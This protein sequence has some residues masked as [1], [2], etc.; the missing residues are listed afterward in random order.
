MSP[1]SFA[2]GDFLSKVEEKVVK[3]TIDGLQK[4]EIDFVGFVF[5]GLMNCN[6]EP[7]VIEYN[8]RMGDPETQVVLPRIESDFL[9]HLVAAAK[10]DLGSETIAFKEETATT[11]VAVAGGYPGSYAKGKVISGLNN[12]SS[13]ITF[14]AGTQMIADTVV[15][16]GGRVI[17]STGL[18]DNI[19]SALDQSYKN[20]N[21]ICWDNINFRKDIGQ[22]LLKLQ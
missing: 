9:G 13:A 16:N 14:H 19:Q 11:V 2:K 6:G 22:D 3:R 12:G 7:Y 21:Q 18:G 17:A 4:D 8:V 5:I 20:L 15:T 10:R 1:V